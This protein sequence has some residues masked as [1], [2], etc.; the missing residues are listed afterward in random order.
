MT[1]KNATESGSNLVEYTV[2]EI[3]GSIKRTMEAAFDQVRVR[4]EISGYRGLHSSGHAYFALKDDRSRIEAV[5]WKGAFSKLRTRPE[6]GMEVIAVG[7]I[8]TFPG[9]SKYQI[10]I[11]SL[12]PAG[13]GAL[14]ALIEERK[15]K[16]QAEGLFEPS[17]KQLLPYMPTVVGVVTSPTGAVIRDILHRIAD[18]YPLHVV[19]WPVRVQG[20]GA[21]QEIANAIAGFNALEV[22][23][24]IARPDVLIVARGGG[25]LE[26]LWC[27]NDEAVVRAA[28][29][30]DIP[31]ISA[32][33]HET[34]WTLI[35]FASD[36]R[37]PTPTGAAEMA[38]PVK[39]DLEALVASLSARLSGAKT[40]QMDARRRQLRDLMRALPSLDQL[41]ALPRRRFD[42]ASSRLGRGLELTTINKRRAFEKVSTNL[43]PALL[44]AKFAEKRQMLADRSIRADRVIERALDRN[45]SR[46]ARADAVFAGFPARLKGEAARQIERLGNLSRRTLS[47]MQA[48]LARHRQALVAQE[49]IL[50]S[51][52]YESVLQ[53]GYAVVRVGDRLV[54]STTMISDGDRLAIQ[55]G[56]GTVKAVA[57]DGDPASAPKKKAPPKPPTQGS[58]F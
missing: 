45:R 35:D 3:S 52:S 8:T 49:R 16:L 47:T 22:G 17:R 26:D 54:T 18:R 38:V 4:G 40:R 27:F 36:R 21:G 7:K 5:I 33:G 31:L 51:L 32:V 34:D 28:A 48:L 9:S 10:M 1:E 53:R 2:T 24:P 25:S 42:E 56:D 29:S 50:K 46:V 19:L 43:R 14:M 23:G 57:G 55:F 15:R 30:S 11:E 6:E 39:A 12:E 13:V 41:L 20:E 44:W 37:A 58:L